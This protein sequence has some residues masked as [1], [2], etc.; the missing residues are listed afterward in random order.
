[1]SENI[2]PGRHMWTGTIRIFLAEA[3]ILPTGFITAVFLARYLGPGGY[4]MFAL[5]SRLIVWVEWTSITGFSGTT[6][7]FVGETPDWRP[8]GSSVIHLHFIIGIGTSILLW[9]FAPPISA[10]FDVP[11]ISGY[12]RLFAVA[13]PVLSLASA[14]SYILVGP[15]PS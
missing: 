3:L 1:M 5:V 4:G 9:L 12:I 7:K 13:L 6:I 14:C 2:S 11:E 10:L 15:G 8:I